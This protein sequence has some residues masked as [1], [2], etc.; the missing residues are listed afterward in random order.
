MSNIPTIRII[1][2][3][4]VILI[5]SIGSILISQLKFDN[6]PIDGLELINVLLT[7][8]T[9]IGLIYTLYKQDQESKK[10]E[11]QRRKQLLLDNLPLLS[12]SKI[13]KL[14]QIHITIKCVKNICIRTCF[15]ITVTT[16]EGE[17][18]ENFHYIPIIEEN[19]IFKIKVNKTGL[20]NLNLETTYRDVTY[21]EYVTHWA[22]LDTN[23]GPMHELDS[24]TLPIKVK[25]SPS[26][27]YKVYLENHKENPELSKIKKVTGKK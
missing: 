6:K 15:K 9:L 27:D 7:T 18:L 13:E 22:L 11:I 3:L 4:I 23:D 17:E 1:R 8:S 19:D 26:V 21:T 12:F 14:D 2:W 5:I 16:F 24:G 10:G 25:D 20:N